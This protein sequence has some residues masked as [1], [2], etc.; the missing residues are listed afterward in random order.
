[1]L[2]LSKCVTFIHFANKE[3]YSAFDGN[4]YL[5]AS[6]M[7]RSGV[8]VQK[9][10]EVLWTMSVLLFFITFP[11]HLKIPIETA[12]SVAASANL[13]NLVQRKNCQRMTR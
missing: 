8:D 4:I 2:N 10:N 1:M 3:L 9:F 5:N 6:A 11:Y 13:F 7:Q 12:H